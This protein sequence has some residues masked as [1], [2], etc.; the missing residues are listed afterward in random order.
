M[1][2][3]GA[4]GEPGDISIAPGLKGE[5]G[6][7]GK[8]GSTGQPGVNGLPGRDGFPGQPGFKGE[9][10]SEHIVIFTVVCPSRLVFQGQ[11][12]SIISYLTLRPKRASRV[13]VD[14]MGTLVL[15]ALLEK[16]VP[17]VCLVLA[18]LEILERREVREE[19]DFL[20]LLGYLVS[21]RFAL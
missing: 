10:V 3:P 18:D 21:K 1:G 6:L 13:N 11:L 9:P 16:E 19:Q 12:F 4:V 2:A 7:P 5:K 8:P 17:L 20:E 15:L 14:Q